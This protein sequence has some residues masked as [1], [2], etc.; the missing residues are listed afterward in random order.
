MYDLFAE[1]YNKKTNSGLCKFVSGLTDPTDTVLEC[2]CGTGMLTKRIAGKCSKLYATDFS[3]EMLKKAR[4]KCR[5]YNNIAFKR[6]DITNLKFP[7]NTFDKVIAANV[8]H[9]LDDPEKAIS[10][11]FRVCKKGGKVI[12]PTYI[13]KDPSGKTGLCI[14]TVKK[15]GTD[16]KRMFTYDTYKTFFDEIGIKN[17]DFKL[18]KGNVP[19]AAAVMT[20]K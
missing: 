16:F 13:N 20:K 9:L 7:D 17:A 5:K 2:A 18:V 1:V 12:I 10:E 8:I 6:A 3:V 15:A 19:C 14:N 11:L 4:K